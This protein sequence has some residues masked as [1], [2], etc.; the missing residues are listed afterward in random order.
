MAANARE[1]RFLSSFAGEEPGTHCLAMPR[2]RTGDVESLASSNIGAD[3]GDDHAT[4]CQLAP[5]WDPS[6]HPP[7]MAPAFDIATA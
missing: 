7:M 6:F 5:A 1:W 4:Q 2:P 3:N